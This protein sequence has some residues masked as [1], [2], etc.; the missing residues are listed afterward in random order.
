MS[1]GEGVDGEDRYERE[2]ERALLDWPGCTCDY[3]VRPLGKLH[4]INM[5]KGLV[6]LN[7]ATDCPHHARPNRGKR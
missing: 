5:G 6:R 2:R 7:D 4:G 1:D 3:G